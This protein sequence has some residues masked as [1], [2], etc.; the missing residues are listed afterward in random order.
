MRE[1]LGGDLVGF[2]KKQLQVMTWWTGKQDAIICDGAIRAGKTYAMSCGFFLWSMS[3]F[4][5]SVFAL[6]GKTVSA[7]RRNVVLQLPRWLGREFHITE[8]RG[9]NKLTVRLGNRE[10]TYY[11]FGG[12]DESSYMLIQGITLA[13]VFLDEVAL[14]PRSFVEQACARCSVAGSKM[15]FNCNPGS[16]E[17]WFYKA[18]VVQAAEKNALHLHFSMEDNPGLAPA[19]RERY[20]RLYTGVFYQRYILGE[21]CQAEGLVYAFD[22]ERHT[23]TYTGTGRYFLSVDYGTQNPF[24][25]GLWCLAEGKAYRLREFYHNG[26]EKGAMTDE[27]YYE[28]LQALAGDLP[29]EAVVIDPSAASM[30]ALL[31]RRGQFRVRKAKNGILPGIRLVSSLLQQEKLVISPGCVDTIREFSLYRWEEDRDMPVK[32]NDHAMDDIRYFCATIL[33][34]MN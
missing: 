8:H 17:H 32:E 13:G 24:S 22:K 10:N 34:R 9:E 16:P 15:W 1:V 3:C 7:L 30:I 26:R 2:S 12:Q 23:G 5:N 11:L 18:W 29:V 25:A 28:A 21:W 4:Q 33:A 31:R 20:Q 6:C 14:M 27:E 19:V